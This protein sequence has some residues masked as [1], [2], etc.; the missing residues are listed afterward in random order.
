V[1]LKAI[2]TE[3]EIAQV[4]GALIENARA[5]ARINTLSVN[6]QIADWATIWKVALINPDMSAYLL[7]NVYQHQRR[8]PS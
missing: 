8:A 1:Q 7:A 5:A 6:G 2:S 4:G 3:D